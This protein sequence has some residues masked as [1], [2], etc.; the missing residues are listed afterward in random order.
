MP[1][2]S[3]GIPSPAAR[4]KPL[5][6]YLVTFDIHGAPSPPGNLYSS[7]YRGIRQRFGGRHFCKDFGQFCLVRSD[8]SVDTVKERAK[9]VIDRLGNFFAARDIV[10]FSVGGE[11]SISRG[12][13]DDEL[14]D[15]RRFFVAA[16]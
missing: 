13:C 2:P 11:I 6:L 4:R 8:E 10:V 7:I 1:L 14:R 15:F 12:R 3:Q 16:R 9:A 5:A